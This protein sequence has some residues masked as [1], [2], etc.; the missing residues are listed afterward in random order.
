M[1][2]DLRVGAVAYHTMEGVNDSSGEEKG[3][4]GA[5]CPGG[6]TEADLGFGAQL[7]VE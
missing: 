1:P 6:L 5:G 7:L 2:D 3:T 4:A